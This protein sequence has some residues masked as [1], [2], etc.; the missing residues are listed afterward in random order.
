MARPVTVN[1]EIHKC[2]LI[3][4]YARKYGFIP[5]RKNGNNP[6]MPFPVMRIS[7]SDWHLPIGED[8]VMIPIRF[9]PY[10]GKDLEDG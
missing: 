4:I 5:G 2:P 10:C 6:V 1:L 3:E 8:D 7:G 9:C